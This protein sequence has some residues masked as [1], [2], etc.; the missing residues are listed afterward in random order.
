MYG[1]SC[2]WSFAQ[3]RHTGSD[4]GSKTCGRSYAGSAMPERFVRIRPETAPNWIQRSSSS[5]V[6]R[7]CAPKELYP[8]MSEPQRATPLMPIVSACVTAERSPS[9]PHTVVGSPPQTFTEQRAAPVQPER[10][11]RTSGRPSPRVMPWSAQ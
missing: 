4:A 8:P 11:K 1:S 2:V 10:W 9:K 6:S 5:R 7:S 3:R